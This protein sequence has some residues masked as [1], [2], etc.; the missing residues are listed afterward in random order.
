MDHGISTIEQLISWTI[1]GK[2]QIN[3]THFRLNKLAHT[4]YQKS[5]ISILGMSGYVI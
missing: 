2:Y 4:I 5:P 3:L 1:L